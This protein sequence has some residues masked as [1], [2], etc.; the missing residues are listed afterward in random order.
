MSIETDGDNKYFQLGQDSSHSGNR[1][2]TSTDFTGVS[3]LTNYVVEFDLAIRSG[4]VANR[5]MSQFVLTSTDTSGAT[6]GNNSGVDSGDNYILKLATGPS[7]TTWTVN[8]SD[9]TV[10]L[11]ADTWVHVTVVVNATTNQANVTIESEG[12]SEPLCN[13]DV[14][15]NGQGILKGIYIL[16]GRGNGLTKVDNIKVY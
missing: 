16:S 6:S 14:N 10:E 13:Y 3:D 2:A 4:N 1:A 12:A 15:F 8:D 9:K 11:A 7:S 5:S